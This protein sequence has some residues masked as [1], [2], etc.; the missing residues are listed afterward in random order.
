MPGG[1]FEHFADHY[2][3][4]PDIRQ[5]TEHE[6]SYC[7]LTLPIKTNGES[8]RSV[9][10]MAVAPLVKTLVDVNELP[11]PFLILI[12]TVVLI[13]RCVPTPLPQLLLRFTAILIIRCASHLAFGSIRFGTQ[14]S[15]Y[16]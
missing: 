4:L 2:T 11:L 8:P 10:D 9:V 3:Q 1:L 12:F 14:L 16:T 15:R 6:E 7:P 13:I 5:A